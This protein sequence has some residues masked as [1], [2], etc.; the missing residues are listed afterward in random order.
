M[1]LF[2]SS[3]RRSA[4]SVL[5]SF[6]NAGLDTQM[7]KTIPHLEGNI[8]KDGGSYAYSSFGGDV[9]ISLDGKVINGHHYVQL[10]VLGD[11]GKFHDSGKEKEHYFEVPVRYVRDRKKVA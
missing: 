4:A 2:G 6:R 11:D 3:K 10:R 5:R 1:R 9:R 8:A 7:L